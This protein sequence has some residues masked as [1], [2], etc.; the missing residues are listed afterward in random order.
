MDLSL[1]QLTA[2]CPA[3]A[4]FHPGLVAGARQYRIDSL[5]RLRHWLAQCALESDGFTRLVENLNYS[6]AETLAFVFRRYFDRDHNKQI[7]T[8][9][10]AFASAY[11]HNPEKLGN[12][13]YANRMGNGDEASGE[14]FKNRGHG[15]IQITGHDNIL[16]YSR[17][18]YGDD[19][20]LRDPSMLTRDPDAGRS[21]AWFWHV[22]GLNYWADADNIEAISGLI[23]TGS[24][25]GK[26]RGL[27][28]GDRSDRDSRVDWYLH[29]CKTIV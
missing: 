12:Y 27:D 11:T 14:G 21:A 5:L 29:A 1:A 9:E 25:T 28:D 4:P 23:N 3:A 2:F 18:V 16:A 26:A 22:N 15:P 13:V 10:L 6:K 19:R 8:F 17:A 20:V 24:I 7:S